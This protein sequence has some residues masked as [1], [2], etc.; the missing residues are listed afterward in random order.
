M[1]H[2]AGRAD[3]LPD[4]RGPLAGVAVPAGREDFL[5]GRYAAAEVQPHAAEPFG[6]VGLRAGF[7]AIFLPPAGDQAV[8]LRD[9]GRVRVAANAVPDLLGGRQGWREGEQGGGGEAG[10]HGA[11]GFV[12]RTG[13]VLHSTIYTRPRGRGFV[14][15][16]GPR[17]DSRPKRPRRARAARMTV[18]S[19]TT[20]ELRGAKCVPCEGGVP[21]L[22]GE[23]VSA[24]LDALDGW[25][26]ADG[27]D[28][29]RKTWNAGTF[30]RALAFFNRVGDLAEAEGHHPDL[31]LTG[32]RHAEVVLT[33]HAIGGLSENDFILAAKIDGLGG[34]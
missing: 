12:E 33:T 11:A 2:E 19:P 30:E 26:T 10:G 14:V 18:A 13:E 25:E 22:T 15:F 23:E 5:S 4:L 8:D 17:P 24:R 27:G 9:D 29:I 32:Y 31:H 28:A 16:G 21:K 34:P 3:Q 1:V 6:V 20:A 7:D